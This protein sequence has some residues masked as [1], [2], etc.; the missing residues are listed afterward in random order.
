MNA[1]TANSQFKF[2]LPNLSYVDA[3]WEEPNLRAAVNREYPTRKMGLAGWLT[4]WIAAF[5]AW[6]RDQQAV[7]ELGMMSDHELMDIGISRSDLNRVFMPAF[8]EDLRQRG[9][10]A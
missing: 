3:S 1:Q 10:H 2:E 6:Q 8:N 5:R 7:S 9:N 4:G